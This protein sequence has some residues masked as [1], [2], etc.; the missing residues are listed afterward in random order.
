M[1]APGARDKI[2]SMEV[3]ADDTPR[4]L[5]QRVAARGQLAER[6]FWLSVQGGPGYSDWDW[7]KA[8]RALATTQLQ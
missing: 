2:L 8:L 1:P 3:F 4:T 7:D 6:S 5:L